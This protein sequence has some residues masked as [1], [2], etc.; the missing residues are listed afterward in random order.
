MGLHNL[1]QIAE[2][3]SLVSKI[4]DYLIIEKLFKV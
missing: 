3:A 2:I 1:F 4:T